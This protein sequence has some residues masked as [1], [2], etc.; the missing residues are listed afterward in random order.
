[1]IDKD[2]Q[3]GIFFFTPNAILPSNHVLHIEINACWLNSLSPYYIDL[4][5]DSLIYIS[6]AATFHKVTAS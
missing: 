3:S 6:F 1:M 2:C 5:F 4:Q